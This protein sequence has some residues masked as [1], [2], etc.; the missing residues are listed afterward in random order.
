MS[1]TLVVFAGFY[2]AA[3]H[4]VQY[5]NTLAEALRGRLVLLHVNRASVYDP[6]AAMPAHYH[7]EELARQTETAAALHRMAEELS[8]HPT[9]EVATDLLPTI[10]QDQAARHRPALFVLSPPYQPTKTGPAWP[11]AAPTCCA[12]ATTRCWWCPR[13]R[14]PSRCPAVF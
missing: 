8:T 11:P 4:T 3:R 1:L 2:Q 7:Q 5:A 6:Y 9:V 12:A 13:P 14:P 10:A